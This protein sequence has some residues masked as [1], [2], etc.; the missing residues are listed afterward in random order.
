[1]TPDQA[2]RA[3]TCPTAA[4]SPTCPTHRD[5]MVEHDASEASHGDFVI[6]PAGGGHVAFMVTHGPCGERLLLT[7]VCH[8][9]TLVRIAAE[10]ICARI[11]RS[12]PS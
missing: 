9:D 8:L 11:A 1:M 3:C 2:A 4:T 5:V 6:V 12:E 7:Q 10:H